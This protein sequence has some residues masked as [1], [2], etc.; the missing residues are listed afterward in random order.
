MLVYPAL[1]R[2]LARVWRTFLWLWI[3]HLVFVALVCHFT[4]TV[5]IMHIM[6]SIC[7]FCLVY[8][9]GMPL[10]CTFFILARVFYVFLYCVVFG[11][12]ISFLLFSTMS[13]PEFLAYLSHNLTI[14]HFL[15]FLVCVFVYGIDLACLSEKPSILY[16]FFVHVQVLLCFCVFFICGFLALWWEIWLVF[17]FS[18]YG[19]VFWRAWL[20]LVVACS[21][22]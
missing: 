14:Y 7:L 12:V 2:H 16:Q 5:Y 17:V 8:G 13:Y 20:L 18:Y 19:V 9:F 10:L 22:T 6:W 3:L 4:K 21:F 11:F 15:F 1:W